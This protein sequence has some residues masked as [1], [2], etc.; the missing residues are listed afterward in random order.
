M[1]SSLSS[2]HQDQNLVFLPRVTFCLGVAVRGEE[3]TGRVDVWDIMHPICHQLAE[4]PA[5]CSSQGSSELAQ[6][7]QRQCIHLH[8]S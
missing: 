7:T 1:S 3:Q 5:P 2:L 6:W 4:T 8:Q